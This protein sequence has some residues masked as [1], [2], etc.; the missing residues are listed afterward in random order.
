MQLNKQDWHKLQI[1]LVILGAVIIMVALFLYLRKTTAVARNMHCKRSRIYST[2]R[3]NIINLQ[4]WRKTPLVKTCRSTRHLSIKALWARSD[5]LN[6]WMSCVRNT[7]IISC[8]ELNTALAS[9]RTTN[10]ALRQ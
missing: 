7:K 10:Q 6:G 2:Q 8:L 4:D 9:K 5:G 1:P 3:G